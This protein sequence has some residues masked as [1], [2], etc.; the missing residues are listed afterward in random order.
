M[1]KKKKKDTISTKQ[2]AQDWFSHAKY[3]EHEPEFDGCGG[4]GG[5]GGGVR[6]LLKNEENNRWALEAMRR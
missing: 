3:Q 4:C 1:K 2:Y 5:V 6:R